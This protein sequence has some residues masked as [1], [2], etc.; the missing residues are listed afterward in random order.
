MGP[1]RYA[2][3]YIYQIKSQLKVS[4]VH[5]AFAYIGYGQKKSVHPWLAEAHE[6]LKSKLSFN[7]LTLLIFGPLFSLTRF[8]LKPHDLELPFSSSNTPS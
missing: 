6:D 8:N 7:I 5:A 2:A 1:R 3:I 4:I